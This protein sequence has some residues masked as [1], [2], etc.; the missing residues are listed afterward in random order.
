MCTIVSVDVILFQL[1]SLAFDLK[2][3]KRAGISIK[4]H[5]PLILCDRWIV[6]F[7]STSITV[8]RHFGFSTKQRENEITERERREKKEVSL[9]IRLSS[10][11]KVICSGNKMWVNCKTLIHATDRKSHSKEPAPTRHAHYSEQ[12]NEKKPSS[13]LHFVVSPD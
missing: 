1:F 13:D 2:Q 11:W 10:K 6:S 4:L 5:F 12:V 7:T 8:R 3:K 9:Q